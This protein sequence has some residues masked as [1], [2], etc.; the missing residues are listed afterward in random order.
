MEAEW[1]RQVGTPTSRK[2]LK[3]RLSVRIHRIPAELPR[4]SKLEP[5]HPVGPRRIPTELLR[6]S[7]EE[8]SRQPGRL[9]GPQ[10]FTTLPTRLCL[11]T[12]LR[13]GALQVESPKCGVCVLIFTSRGVFIR[14][15]GGVTDLVKLV[16]RQVVAGRPSHVASRPCASASTDFLHRLGLPLLVYTRVPEA[17]AKLT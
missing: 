13:M 1:S 3:Q 11:A 16:T 4:L 2:V 6:S 8:G 7:Y 5:R 14:V 12:T 9:S 17:Q 10:S 15:Q